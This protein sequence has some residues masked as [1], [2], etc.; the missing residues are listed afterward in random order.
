M[1]QDISS[2]LLKIKMVNSCRSAYKLTYCSFH[3]RRTFHKPPWIQ[4]R[5]FVLDKELFCSLHHWLSQRHVSLQHRKSINHRYSK[6]VLTNSNTSRHSKITHNVLG[7]DTRIIFFSNW[8]YFWKF[9]LYLDCLS[10]MILGNKEIL[11]VI[12]YSGLQ[13]GYHFVFF[14]WRHTDDLINRWQ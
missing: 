8:K 3:K 13:Y 4:C 2:K 14:C 12:N 6:S 1:W 10:S 7:T 11:H 9:K 5:R